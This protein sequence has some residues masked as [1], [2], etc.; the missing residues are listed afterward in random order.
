MAATSTTIPI[1]FLTGSDPVE[2]GLVASLSRPGGNMTRVANLSVEVG[3]QQLELLHLL[4][5]T[6][7]VIALLVNPNV[8]ILAAFSL[9]SCGP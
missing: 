3:A 8:P 2:V 1:V 9:F 5:P 6:A 4:V 7:A